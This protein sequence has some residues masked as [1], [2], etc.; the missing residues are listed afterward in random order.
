MWLAGPIVCPS[1]FG[2]RYA[3]GTYYEPPTIMH[4]SRGVA[5]DTLL[6]WNCSPELTRLTLRS[7]VRPE[8]IDEQ[9]EAC[10]VERS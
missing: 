4:V 10:Q 7:R 2:V 6:R 8:V 5:G 3:S 1:K 9:P